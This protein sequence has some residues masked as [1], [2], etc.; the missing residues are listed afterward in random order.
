MRWLDS[1]LKLPENSAVMPGDFFCLSFSF[2]SF[3]FFF[4][5]FFFLFFFFFFGGGV[6]NIGLGGE[7]RVL[8]EDL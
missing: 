8:L 5:F 2:L 3:S 1:N 6:N 4:F 7:S